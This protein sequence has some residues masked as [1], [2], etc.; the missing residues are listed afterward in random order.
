[1]VIIREQGL[2]RTPP[3]ARDGVVRHGA[4]TAGSTDTADA[5]TE[6]ARGRADC[7]QLLGAGTRGKGAGERTVRGVCR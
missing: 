6:M 3:V 2:Q 7:Q 5:P 4:V 1:M